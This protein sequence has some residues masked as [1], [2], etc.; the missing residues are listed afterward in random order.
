MKILSYNIYRGGQAGAED[1]TDEIIAVIRATDADIVGLC[2]C[3]QF[4]D[5]DRAR[6]RH[7]ERALG[8]R[9]V[10]NRAQ[11]GHH[12]A[13][14]YREH[15]DVV[16]IDTGEAMMYHGFAS[17]VADLPGLGR[18]I[19]VMTHLHPRSSIFRLAEAQ[20][21]LGKAVTEPNG[22]AMGDF[23]SPSAY[24]EVPDFENLPI[25]RRARLSETDGSTAFG[26]PALFKSYGFVDLGES[27]A[28]PTFPTTI[29]GKDKGRGLQLRIDYM[30][31]SPT[32][33]EAA[34]LETIATPEAMTASDHLPLLCE[35]TP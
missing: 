5:D 12:V 14:L 32:L 17:V 29:Y 16:E 3:T 26:V 23:N 28:A 33:A 1:K 19:V 25:D 8:M 35:L 7:Y 31:A 27:D 34:R 30:F 21:V 24:D 6:L 20:N 2:E 22:L 13:V 11:S 15:I 9:A 4:H 18:T 10:I